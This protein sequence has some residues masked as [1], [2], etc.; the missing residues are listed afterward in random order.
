[1]FGAAEAIKQDL[2][3]GNMK[4]VRNPI[5]FYLWPFRYET[6]LRINFPDDCKRFEKFVKNNSSGNV[7][8]KNSVF[9]MKKGHIRMKLL[10][11]KRDDA[12]ILRLKW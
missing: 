11:Q 4:W 2:M 10:T 12:V 1:M 9:I 7:K 8:T 5:T 6:V 3:W